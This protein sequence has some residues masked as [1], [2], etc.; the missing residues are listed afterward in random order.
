MSRQPRVL[1]LV[2]L[3]G[4]GKTTLEHALYARDTRIRL[5]DA[6]AKARYLPFLARRARLC[7][8]SLMWHH[9]RSRRL[10]LD[11]I[12]LIGYLEVWGAHLRRD[13]PTPGRVTV[14]NPGS[15]Y[16]LAALRE[17]APPCFDRYSRGQWWDGML[18]HWADVIDLA[19]WLDAPDSIL[20]ERVHSREQW[21][22]AK[23]QPDGQ[24]MERF[25]LLRTRYDDILT[26]MAGQADLEVLH[27]RT[28]QVAPER[29]ADSVLAALRRLDS[30]AGD[31]FAAERTTQ[32]R[33]AAEG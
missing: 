30:S 7:L 33:S 26:E 1:E 15:V 6:P 11:E 5:V 9:R 28:D 12:K 16:W 20:L 22:Q 4:A 21:H 27:F 19:V 14:L 8:S 10:T 24:V 18:N 31:V 32:W 29:I 25:G 2:G 23:A 3:A 17:F 13:G